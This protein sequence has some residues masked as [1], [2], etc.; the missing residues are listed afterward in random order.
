MKSADKY[1]KQVNE[2]LKDI[3]CAGAWND[4]LG[5]RIF[6]MCRTLRKSRWSKRCEFEFMLLDAERALRDKLKPKLTV[7]QGGNEFLA[8]RSRAVLT[9]IV[10]S[11]LN[12][13]QKAV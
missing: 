7:I 9:L 11:E 2:L 10:T 6:R 3:E 12:N 1:A 5:E 8:R 4:S 13:K